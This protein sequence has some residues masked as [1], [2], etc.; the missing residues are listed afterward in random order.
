MALFIHKIER[1][2]ATKRSFDNV[3]T[4]Q[5]SR[6]CSSIPTTVRV[7]IGIGLLAIGAEVMSNT[8]ELLEK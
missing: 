5:R 6:A 3:S 7:K 1:P 2:K 8:T 4:G